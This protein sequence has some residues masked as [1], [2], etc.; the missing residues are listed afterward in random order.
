VIHDLYSFIALDLARQRSLEGERAWLAARLAA[1]A[2][3]RPSRLRRLLARL[4]ASVSL[5]SAVLA[6]RLDSRVAD[7]LGRALAPAK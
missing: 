6:R 3:P 1:D 4:L 2:P 7:D 5:G